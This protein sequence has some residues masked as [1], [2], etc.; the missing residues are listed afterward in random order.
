MIRRVWM[1]TGILALPLVVSGK[2][3]LWKEGAH[4]WCEGPECEGP[5]ACMKRDWVML[6]TVLVVARSTA[7]VIMGVAVGR[8]YQVA[9]ARW[10]AI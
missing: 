9:R 5:A 4:A 10:Q 1:A 3:W 2:A 8:F 6:A 7:Y